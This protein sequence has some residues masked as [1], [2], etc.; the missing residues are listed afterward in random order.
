M[1]VVK[2]SSNLTINWLRGAKTCHTGINRTAGWNIPVGLL[3]DSGRMPMM[4][5]RVAKGKACWV[6][7]MA[8]CLVVLFPGAGREAGWRR[9]LQL[10]RQTPL[11]LLLFPF[12]AV[13]DYFKASCVPGATAVGDPASLCELCKGDPA[14][15]S[16]CEL[17]PKEEYYDYL[18]AF[19]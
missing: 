7:K 11:L 13:S 1:A 12:S 3:L 4:D 5:C 18:G 19:R 9:V 15:H 2:A 17:S 14:G 6:P 10:E 8:L 16:K